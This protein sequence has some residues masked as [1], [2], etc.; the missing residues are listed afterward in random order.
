[1]A[2]PFRGLTLPPRSGG[3]IPRGSRGGIPPRMLFIGPFLRARLTLSLF[4]WKSFPRRSKRQK[5][6]FVL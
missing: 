5:R 2:V 6:H 1:M 3:G 4:P